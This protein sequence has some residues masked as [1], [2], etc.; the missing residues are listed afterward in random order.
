MGAHLR[1]NACSLH[2]VYR[3]LVMSSKP[4]YVSSRARHLCSERQRSVKK[5]NHYHAQRLQATTKTQHQMESALLL[6]VI[7]AQSA[8]IL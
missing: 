8:A 3:K 5:D 1:P 7:I 6:D 2:Y 4:A